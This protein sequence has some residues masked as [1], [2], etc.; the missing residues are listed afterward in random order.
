LKDCCKILKGQIR[1]PTKKKS[2]PMPNKRKS[3]QI[4]KMEAR[5]GKPY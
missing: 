5:Q 1:K 2:K 3:G 4:K